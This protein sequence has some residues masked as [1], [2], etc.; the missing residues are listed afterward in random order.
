MREAEGVRVFRDTEETDVKTS[1]QKL[2]KRNRV[3]TRASRGSITIVLPCPALLTVIS[4]FW[5]P[6]L[7]ENKFLLC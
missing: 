5:P 6:K 7:R 3:S 1:Y 4:G 2:E